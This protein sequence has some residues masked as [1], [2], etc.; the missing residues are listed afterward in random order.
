MSLETLQTFLKAIGRGDGQVCVRALLP[1]KIPLEEA[2]KLGLAGFGKDG[3][4]VPFPIAMLFDNASGKLARL[5]KT[6]HGKSKNSIYVDGFKEL[7]T[8]N[9]KG[10]GL[11]FVPNIGGF[12]KDEITN[13]G[14]LFHESDY[15]AVEH[16]QDEIDRIT[17]EFGEPSAVVKTRKSL[18]A[19]WQCL[20]PIPADK[21]VELQTRWLLYA[22]CDDHSL[23][24]P[25]QLMRLPGFEHV[26]WNAEESVIERVQCELIH[27]SDAVY[28]I[29]QFEEILPEL[30]S[31]ERLELSKDYPQSDGRSM[32]DFAPYLEG[33]NPNGRPG[34]ITAKCPVHHGYSDDSLHIY[35]ESGGF[36]CHGGCSPAA[37]YGA[38]LELAVSGG[39]E[40][41][42]IK[43]DDEDEVEERD[44]QTEV[45][46]RLG[47][48]DI[49]TILHP[50]LCDQIE[51]IASVFGQ[52]ACV[53]ASCLLPIS[54]SLLKTATNI[55]LGK[56]T[57]HLQPSILWLA[58]V[59]DSDDGKSPILKLLTAAINRMQSAEYADYLAKKAKYELDLATWEALSK[60][61]R[62]PEDK[63]QPV[64]R[65]RRF[66]FSNFTTESLALSIEPNKQYGSLLH[67]DELAGMVKGLGQ[68]KKGGGSDRPEFLSLYDGGRIDISR[69][70]DGDRY[71]EE[72]SL[73]VVG[74][75]QPCVLKDIMGELEHVDGYW[76]RFFYVRMQN[77]KMPSIDW[78]ADEDTGIYQTLSE[79]YQRL[80]S[81]DAC[82]YEFDVSARAIWEQWH[83]FTE[84]TRLHE[85]HPAKKSLFRKARARA[86][87]IAM[88]VHCLNAAVDGESQPSKYIK[89]ETVK[90]AI[91]FTKW[92]LNQIIT[93][94]DDFG[95]SDSP[96]T[97]KMARFIERFKDSGFVDWKRVRNWW[98]AKDK[99]NQEEVLAFMN[100]LI[101][102]EIVVSNGKSKG[103]L[104]ISVRDSSHLVTK[105]PKPSTLNGSSRDYEVSHV[106]K[107]LVT[108]SSHAIKSDSQDADFSHM[109]KSVTKPLS[110]VTKELVT[111]EEHTVKEIQR[112]CDY[113]TT[114]PK[115]NFE[116]SK[117]D[118]IKSIVQID[119]DV[120]KGHLG[121][122]TEVIDGSNYVIQFDGIN[123]TFPFIRPDE[124]ELIDGS[125]PGVP[126]NPRTTLI[127]SPGRV[128]VDLDKLDLNWTPD[129]PIP[130]WK[131][132]ASGFKPYGELSKLYIDIETA[133]LNPE[134]DR[135]YMVGLMDGE[136]NK[137][138]LVDPDEKE[139]L[140]ALIVFLVKNKPR[141]LIGHNLFEFDLPFIIARCKKLGVKQ[142]FFTFYK[143]KQTGSETMRITSAS[144][145]GKPIEF[146]PV[147][148]KGVQILD[149]LQQVAI[150]DKQSAKL[151]S[152]GLKSSVIALGLR[153]DRRLEL[154]HQEIIEC[155][156]TGDLSTLQT[157]L[158]HD[159]EDNQLLADFLLP[160]VYGQTGYVPGLSFQKLAIA[161]PAL[162]AQKIHQSLMPSA[163]PEA[164]EPVQY[165]GGFVQLLSPGLHHNV[166]KIDVSSLYPS[167]ML[168]YGVC[169]RKDS[170][171]QFLGALQ[172]M[173]QERLRLKQLAK[174]GDSEASFQEK[175]LKILI[176][177]SYGFLGTGFYSFNDYEAAA[178]VTAYGRKILNLMMETISSCEATVIEVDTDGVLFSHPDPQTVFDLVQESLPNGINIELEMQNCGLYAPKAKNYV[179]VHPE[180]KTTVKGLFRKRD[181]YPL[182]WEFPVEFLKLYFNDSPE[183]AMSYYQEVREAI[184]TMNIER[185]TVT[186]K[187]GAGEKALIEMGFG[188]AGDH[189]SF[190]FAEQKRSHA[191][192]G[193]PLKSRPIKSNTS[194]VW[195]EYYMNRLDAVVKDIAG[196]SVQQSESQTN[197]FD[198]A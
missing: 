17:T 69:K 149:T 9:Q 112:F 113:V 71:I 196:S 166:A 38:S 179:I 85:G 100:D 176:N 48:V 41:P 104:Q 70:V 94:Y 174:Q 97:T 161:S 10:Y 105:S 31:V 119:P 145:F 117:G 181:R 116:N 175:A 62:R 137:T 188:K 57:N 140:K 83:D 106:T 99:P 25:G 52:P 147:F 81:F 118:R 28:S 16:Q 122:I 44:L 56:T 30:D 5:Y 88:V 68:Y 121:T 64:E 128:D 33:F 22:N 15:I 162:K 150:W 42:E 49:R 192:T 132:V 195:V 39:Y 89:P 37:V 171:H 65:M 102:K 79:A 50:K 123:A 107:E 163:N 77:T 156:E 110:H 78:D 74:G 148:W 169:S 96:E 93:I 172:Y 60:G 165:D 135:V 84:D 32:R 134:S 193:K 198:A 151:S 47:G 20:Q 190:W 12:K 46:Q 8:L 58:L 75:I 86:A 35:P 43:P 87:R 153:D 131:P 63:P 92:G 18:H 36:L 45:S 98:S 109:T 108:E 184:P 189:V 126:T 168:R 142:S 182:E 91:E 114:V 1:K 55:S 59:G 186:R 6:Q 173:T 90:A 144:L 82:Q 4:L 177:G 124:I 61:D 191:K 157:Y 14:S 146:K 115:N 170:D 27:H 7:Q 130:E 26:H 13:C 129:V 54:A 143:N 80:N 3:K 53:V 139:L 21:W 120:A 152:Y 95:L 133:G 40:L 194:P 76:P 164:D 103:K 197:L 185:L 34:W 19:Y 23:S 183:A 154:T 127:H 73:S 155:W 178:L 180:G 136:G 101:K 51:K 72:T 167:I 29:E 11:Y 67:V 66:V 141:V 111:T 158:E 24:D 138:V 159:L 2:E 187:I 125:S 160:V